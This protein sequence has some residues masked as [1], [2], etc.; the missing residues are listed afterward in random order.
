MTRGAR[1]RRADGSERPA[2]T[3]ATAEKRRPRAEL[4]SHADTKL[5]ERALAAS[6]W[7][8]WRPATTLGSAGVGVGG[9]AGQAPVAAPPLP[10]LKTP[11]YN[12]KAQRVGWPSLR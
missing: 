1:G 6:R 8:V 10:R 5:P 2:T 3:T 7:R 12:S 9:L 4:R 11:P